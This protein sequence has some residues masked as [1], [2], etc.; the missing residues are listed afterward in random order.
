MNNAQ[1]LLRLHTADRADRREEDEEDEKNSSGRSRGRR[2]QKNDKCL[3]TYRRDFSCSL[4]FFAFPLYKKWFKTWARTV[5][6]IWLGS[7]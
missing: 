5:C 1:L 3:S 6:V 2:K 4:L 7:R